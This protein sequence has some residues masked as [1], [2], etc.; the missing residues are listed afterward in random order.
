VRRREARGA[1]RIWRQDFY[2]LQ[3]EL[4]IL[5]NTAH[6]SRGRT[7]VA[8]KQPLLPLPS[9]GTVESLATVA[10]AIRKRKKWRTISHAYQTWHWIIAKRDHGDVWGVAGA[11]DVWS[12]ADIDQAI[13][14]LDNGRK[15]LSS[16]EW[17]GRRWKFQPFEPNRQR[18]FFEP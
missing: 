15:A 1:A 7:L 13:K 12:K 2:A 9:V 14:R 16:L 6:W 10:A 11:A 8:G 3:V 5:T 18:R 17:L 4:D